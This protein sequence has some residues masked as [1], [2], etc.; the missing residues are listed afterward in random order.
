MK[1]IK[2]KNR[3]IV[4]YGY[5]SVTGKPVKRFGL[6]YVDVSGNLYRDTIDGIVRDDY[7]VV[8]KYSYETVDHRG[9][10][11]RYEGTRYRK[12]TFADE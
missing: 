3:K 11:I 4:E 2:N 7:C 8:E 9:F 12:S 6:D 5:Y 1:K 10:P